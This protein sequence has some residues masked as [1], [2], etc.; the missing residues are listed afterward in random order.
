MLTVPPWRLPMSELRWGRFISDQDCIAWVDWKGPF[1]NRFAIHNSELLVP[2]IVSDSN[3]VL[4][5]ISLDMY[6]SFTLREGDLRTSVL[7]NSPALAKLLPDALFGIH[8]HK[9]V[10]RGLCRAANHTSSGWAIHE[11]VHWTL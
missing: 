5:G 2:K 4:P 8:E 11:V 9:W 7:P 10:S 3:L 6:G 1:S